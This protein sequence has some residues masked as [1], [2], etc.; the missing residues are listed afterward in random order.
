VA[1]L[2]GL[3]ETLAVLVVEARVDYYTFHLRYCKNLL[4]SQ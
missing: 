3:A 1:G 4:T 2:A